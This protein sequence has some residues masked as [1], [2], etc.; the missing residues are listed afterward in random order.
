MLSDCCAFPNK[1]EFNN[2]NDKAK[3]LNSIGFK[4]AVSDLIEKILLV[5]V[6]IWQIIICF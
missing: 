3:E 2:W 1:G 6:L 4:I 5:M